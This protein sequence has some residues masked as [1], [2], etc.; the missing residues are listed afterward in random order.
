MRDD[1]RCCVGFKPFSSVAAV[2]WLSGGNRDGLKLG[3][4]VTKK[5]IKLKGNCTV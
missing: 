2:I 1:G 5:H 3:V 4:C